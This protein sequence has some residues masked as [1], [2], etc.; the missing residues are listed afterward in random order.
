MDIKQEVN[1]FIFTNEH[2]GAL[3]V[4]GKWGCGK[5]YLI[6]RITEELNQSEDC[7]LVTVSL[8]GT[9]SIVALNQAIKEKVL[10]AQIAHRKASSVQKKMRSLKE[11]LSPI[12]AVL[13]EHSNIAK[14][15][16]TALSVNL[17][18]FVKV[19]KEVLCFHG[20][21]QKTKKLVLVFDDFERCKID[22]VDLLGAI[23][24]YTENKGI[25]TI[26]IADDSHIQAQQYSEFKEKV[27]ARTLR[28]TSDYDAIIKEIVTNYKETF[29]GY[30][31]FLATNIGVLT[32]IFTESKQ[33]NL[34][35]FKS[36]IIDFE[37]V[38]A[39]WL[40][41]GISTEHMPQVLYAFGVI[42]FEAK[43]GNYHKHSRY[44]YLLTESKAAEKY[45]KLVVSYQF[46]ALQDWAVEGIWSK[47]RFVES[48][49]LKFD[50]QELTYS[51]LF[52]NYDF[53]D[54]DDEII[55]SG[56]PEALELAYSGNL[57]GRDL[58]SLL[59]R[60]QVLGEYGIPLPC[61]IDYPQMLTG[62]R[63][64]ENEIKEGRLKEPG[65][66]TF[67]MPEDVRK[68]APQA[69]ELYADIEQM[70]ERL[71]A[72]GYRRLFIDYLTEPFNSD[73]SK[74]KRQCLVCFDDTLLECFFA[75]YIKASNSEKRE[76]FQTLNSFTF[77]YH[78]ISKTED[79]QV[80]IKNLRTLMMRF[81]TF[82]ED[83][84]DSFTKYVINETIKGI[85]Q[86][87]A[88]LESD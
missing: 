83:E 15:L 70:K 81:S 29:T 33:E 7:V 41:S 24:E 16:N 53:W 10:Y 68:M 28:L 8:F 45:S 57:C 76:L 31:N 62:F 37:R 35:T 23:N 51:E 44:G 13:S 78:E 77:D 71:G 61:E 84:K 46:I 80:T 4:T 34:R 26:V 63:Q 60:T 56:L 22:I 82:K 59:R 86:I 32:Q 50:P 48:V 40:E 12:A 75:A 20:D 39:A 65:N 69:Q 64:R 14:G 54:L 47:E 9:D 38:Y 17:Y 1:D 74:F 36:Y 18:D 6:R 58:I 3:L 88:Q 2:T 55:A 27:I 52:L 30:S 49:R 72:W 25:K 11:F 85:S 66:P 43:A 21:S 87:V 67:I 73:T 5:T 79:V 19:E 42:H